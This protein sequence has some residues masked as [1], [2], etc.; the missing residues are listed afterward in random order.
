[1]MK[2][3]STLAVLVINII[4]QVFFVT[5]GPVF[6]NVNLQQTGRAEQE[7]DDKPKAP[8]HGH[9]IFT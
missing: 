4:I 6:V 2:E 7:N 3:T 9:E 1:M 8:I 5:T